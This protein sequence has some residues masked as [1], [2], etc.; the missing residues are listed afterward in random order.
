M[1][2]IIQNLLLFC[3]CIN[4]Y[5][6]QSAEINVNA[7]TLPRFTNASAVST[8]I[9]NP[10]AGMIIYRNDTQSF[11]FH[12][13]TTWV[14]LSEVDNSQWTST[15]NNLYNTSLGNVGIGMATPN[16]PL[17]F[18]NNL[19]NRKIVLYESIDNDHQYYGFGVTGG[20]LRYQTDGIGA[21]HVFYAAS[22]GTS[23]NELLR[24][25]GNSQIQVGGTS[26]FGRLNV[27]ANS[28]YRD[29]IYASTI[30]DG[31]AVYGAIDGGT[32]RIAAVQGE[33]RSSSQGI[34]N[35]AGVRGVNASTT[36]GT[37]FRALSTTGPR[38]GV[39]GNTSGFNGQY[40][41][42]LHGTM[43]STD[44]RC[45][46]VFGDD[47]GISSGALGYYAANLADYGVYG[48]GS[49]YQ[50]G[51]PGGRKSYRLTE[52]NTQI[53][54]G[55]YGGVMGGWI[56]GLVYG[57]HIKGEQYSL[58]VDGKTYVNEPIAEL[59]S[60]AENNR[61]PAYA[62]TTFGTDV[63]AKGKAKLE[64]GRAVI[65]FH[66]NFKA[67]IT[68]NPDDVVITIAPSGKNKGLYIESQS[69]DGFVIKEND[70]GEGI[71]NFSW[72]A[73]ATRKDKT[74][75]EHPSE[76]LAPDFDSKMNGVMYNDNN[77]DG[78]QKSL[79]W[80]GT[81]VRFDT[82]QVDRSNDGID[83]SRKSIKN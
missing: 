59:V 27:V 34:F 62:L 33:Y 81:R 55:I 14:N 17:Q 11:W 23:S 48:F 72:I 57:T 67:I 7:I 38:V 19:V 24:V 41:F 9:P 74:Q 12:N 79:W 77:T 66:A 60:G 82:P 13:A 42:G 54:L 49:A 29:G 30:F 36:A 26:N 3:F 46:G 40:T 39:I 45:G 52:P 51:L 18:S 28:T 5:A 22:S 16:A 2:T 65:N 20:T 80:D 78:K 43:G 15:G 63:Y 70:G 25:K 69:T 37:G 71:T 73:I 6:Q 10:V 56:R 32:T 53:G 76:V 31:A 58:Y 35:T 47:F 50:A 68:E 21:D 83:R 8:A 64:N 1:K 44:I 4:L 75:I 61:T